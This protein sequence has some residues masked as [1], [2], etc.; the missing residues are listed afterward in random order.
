VEF[1]RRVYSSQLVSSVVDLLASTSVTPK[2][3]PTEY[4][5]VYRTKTDFRTFA[6]KLELMEDFKV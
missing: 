6:K 1:V 5:L 2:P 3:T 4:R